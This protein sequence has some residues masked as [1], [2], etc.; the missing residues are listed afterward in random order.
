MEYVYLNKM[1]IH[2]L[3]IALCKELLILEV[4]IQWQTVKGDTVAPK[5]IHRKAIQY[6]KNTLEILLTWSFLENFYFHL[7]YFIDSMIHDFLYVIS[8]KSGC[9]LKLPATLIG[10]DQSDVLRVR[11]CICFC[12]LPDSTMNLIHIKLNNLLQIVKITLVTNIPDQKPAS[13]SNC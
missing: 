11:I 10:Q 1:C 8:L 2:S 7:L 3:S 5:R 4:S 9:V 6:R 12:Q 13:D